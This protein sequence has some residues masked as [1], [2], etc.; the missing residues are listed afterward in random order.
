MDIEQA[1]KQERAELIAQL[2]RVE[3]SLAAYTGEKKTKPAATKPTNGNSHAKPDTSPAKLPERIAAFLADNGPS[4]VES[5]AEGINAP[6]GQVA[7]TCSRL[8]KAKRLTVDKSVATGKAV[9]DT[10][11]DDP[12]AKEKP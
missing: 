4:E 5:I 12:F 11:T 6:V 3:K 10:V 9:Y 2:A 8:T 1:L 7:T